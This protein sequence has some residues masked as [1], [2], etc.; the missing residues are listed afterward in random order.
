[1]NVGGG[2]EKEEEEEK[3]GLERDSQGEEV[4]VDSVTNSGLQ[5][6]DFLVLLDDDAVCSLGAWDSDPDPFGTVVV[7]V[8][9][10]FGTCDSVTVS[11]LGGCSSL[12]LELGL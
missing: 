1:M 8:E 11:G 9:K 10:P 12:D 3:Y 4:N 2:W 7:V 6:T 5:C